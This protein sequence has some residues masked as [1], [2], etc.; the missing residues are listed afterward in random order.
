MLTKTA[1]VTGKNNSYLI[2]P[3]A[4]QAS[5]PGKGHQGI[6]CPEKQPTLYRH[7]RVADNPLERAEN[8]GRRPWQSPSDSV[9]GF[10]YADW[11]GPTDDLR[12]LPFRGQNAHSSKHTPT[13]PNFPKMAKTNPVRRAAA[14]SRHVTR[15]D[16][17]SD[18]YL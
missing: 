17:N 5:E 14:S 11:C 2:Q 1:I 15:F 16:L 7:S 13:N 10:C 9:V 18:G 6:H 12:E 4:S 3:Q 8:K